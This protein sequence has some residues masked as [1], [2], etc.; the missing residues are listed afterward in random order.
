MGTGSEVAFT[1]PK[2]TQG[3]LHA[4]GAM[5]NKVITKLGIKGE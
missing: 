1:T 2:E 5:W 4:E 3:L